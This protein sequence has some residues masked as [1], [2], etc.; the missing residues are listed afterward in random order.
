[1][2]LEKVAK[3]A[4]DTSKVCKK[5]KAPVK[6]G[7]SHKKNCS[8]DDLIDNLVECL[9]EKKPKMAKRMLDMIVPQDSNSVELPNTRG[10]PTK[11]CL[12]PKNEKNIMFSN[13]DFLALQNE[14]NLSNKATELTAKWMRKHAGNTLLTMQG[15]FWSFS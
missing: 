2:P 9:D 3:S 12:N 10:K 4:D 11:V 14:N 13:D 5:C 7:I 8:T 1:M 6:R 15:C